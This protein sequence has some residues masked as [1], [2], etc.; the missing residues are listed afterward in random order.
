MAEKKKS[1]KKFQSE[2]D[3]IE[4]ILSVLSKHKLYLESLE[5]KVDIISI[6]VDKLKV[7]SGL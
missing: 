2:D 6:S 4:V 3:R 1:K 7:R 5:K